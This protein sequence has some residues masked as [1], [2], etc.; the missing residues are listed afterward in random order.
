MA[1]ERF[2]HRLTN[3]GFCTFSRGEKLSNGRRSSKSK[4][5]SNSWPKVHWPV[6]QRRR[7]SRFLRS[8]PCVAREVAVAEIWAIVK[9]GRFVRV[10]RDEGLSGES[11]AQLF[12]GSCRASMGFILLSALRIPCCVPA[13]KD[14][15]NFA[16]ISWDEAV[17]R[18]A[19]KLKETES[20]IRTG[21]TRCDVSGAQ[22]TTAI[23]SIAS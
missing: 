19:D 23:I 12:Q 9:K 13:P 8:V 1:S 22:K 10:E 18:I 16:K 5:R 4:H 20:S 14:P 17:D 6:S 21:I 7:I 15:E 11:G 2:F 3:V